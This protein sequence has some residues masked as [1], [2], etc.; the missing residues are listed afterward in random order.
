MYRR[1]AGRL[2]VR[3]NESKAS[4][5]GG[6]PGRTGSAAAA[7]PNATIPCSRRRRE[8]WKGN[9]DGCDGKES[10]ELNV[11]R[12]PGGADIECR[13]MRRRVRPASETPPVLRG[14]H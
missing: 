5:G 13:S 6:G 12:S 1:R 10:L 8:W 14:R 9:A 11:S 4:E 3:Q 2:P 7:R